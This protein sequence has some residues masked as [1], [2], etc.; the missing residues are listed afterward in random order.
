MD[1]KLGT[2]KK[3]RTLIPSSS[4]GDFGINHG[5]QMKQEALK[6]YTFFGSKIHKTFLLNQL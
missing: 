1:E 5:S 3:K 2:K 6:F 4:L